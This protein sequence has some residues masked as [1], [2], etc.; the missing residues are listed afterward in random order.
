MYIPRWRPSLGKSLENTANLADWKFQ[1][2][3]EGPYTVVLVGV[4]GSY[5]VVRVGAVG[6]YLLRDHMMYTNLLALSPKDYCLIPGNGA[7]KLVV[8]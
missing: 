2:N 1:Q 3:W 5:T 6:S 7:I 8:I 4:V